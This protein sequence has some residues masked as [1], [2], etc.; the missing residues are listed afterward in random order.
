MQAVGA[1]LADEISGPVQ[2]RKHRRPL[3]AALSGVAELYGELRYE[4]SVEDH[5]CQS[6]SQLLQRLFSTSPGLRRHRRGVDSR[7][8]DVFA[9]EPGTAK[10]VTP[11]EHQRTARR[12]RPDHCEPDQRRVQI[13]GAAQA[14]AKSFGRSLAV[15][16]YVLS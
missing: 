15:A 4:F 6:E 13:T 5:S 14:R 16:K 7:R 9:V 3:P 1:V 11:S 12:S 2:S 10:Q 8:L